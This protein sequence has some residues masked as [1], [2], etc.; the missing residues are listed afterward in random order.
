MSWRNR[1]VALVLLLAPSVA[2]SQTLPSPSYTGLTV[3]GT[4][5]TGFGTAI[6]QALGPL[7]SSGGAG[8]PM[9]STGNRLIFRRAT[10]AATDFV[11]FQ[12]DRNSTYT[13]GVGQT[14]RIMGLNTTIGANDAAQG[15]NLVNITTN[16]STVGAFGTAQ[17]NQ[18]LRPV[19]GTGWV[20]GGVFD[21]IDKTG[22]GTSAAGVPNQ[23]GLEIDLEANGPDDATNAA[24]FGG[25]GVRKGF[26]I[27]GSRFDQANVTQ[28]E[29][30]TVLWITTGVFGSTSPDA[31]F[32]FQQIIGFAPNTQ[33]R[34]VVDTRGAITPTASSNPVSAV[35]MTAGHVIDFNGGAALTSAPGNYL[36]YDAGTSRLKYYVAGVAKWSVDAS[37]NIRAA[38]TVTGS[39]TP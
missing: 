38:G 23:L 35:V 37:G 22:L 25:S 2:I 16:N 6:G 1:L 28:T 5:I 36:A 15:W 3:G 18:V 27:F 30:S 21:T 19:G 4:S 29:V 9:L 12:F 8:L 31:H 10:V 14:N 20:T 26:H 13:G 17:F 24:T 11:D 39:T 32:N 34:T 33:V 7:V